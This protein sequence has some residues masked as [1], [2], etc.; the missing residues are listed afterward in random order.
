MFLVLLVAISVI[1]VI[2][3]V[4]VA[5]NTVN[6]VIFSFY[7][8]IHLYPLALSVIKLKLTLPL[9]SSGSIWLLVVNKV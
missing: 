3:M 4:V 9:L 5:I 8:N 1:L 2:K 6:A 7:I